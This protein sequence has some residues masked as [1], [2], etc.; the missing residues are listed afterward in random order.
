[1]IV[2]RRKSRYNNHTFLLIIPRVQIKIINVRIYNMYLYICIYITWR[3]LS[4]VIRDICIFLRPMITAASE[5]AERRRS[6]LLGILLV[7]LP[8][9]TAILHRKRRR[10]Q[11]QRPLCWDFYEFLIEIWKTRKNNGTLLLLLVIKIKKILL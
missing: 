5:S 9:T 7:F 4:S 3:F 6:L 1:M 2:R 10:R 11:W 8:T